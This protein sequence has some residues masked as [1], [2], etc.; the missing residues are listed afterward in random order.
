MLLFIIYTLILVAIVGLATLI[1]GENK[2]RNLRIRR[3]Y[4]RMILPVLGVRLQVYGDLPTQAGL[5]IGNHRSYFDPIALLYDVFAFPVAKSE[6]AGWP[7]I[8]FGAKV[9]GIIFVKRGSKEGRKNTLQHISNTLSE[10]FYVLNYAEGTTHNKAQTIDFKKGTFAMAATE[11]FPIIPVAIDYKNR[12]D[13]WVGDDTFIRHFWECFGK[14]HTDVKISY[15]Q[16]L[17]SDDQD[18]LLSECKNW[19]DTQL[20]KFRTDWDKE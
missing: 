5:L 12:G 11:G 1:L 8:G 14:A 10:G 16:C 17:Q 3:R 19:I 18:L 2:L 7:L 4:V 20:L 13:A 6:L 9:T 15:G